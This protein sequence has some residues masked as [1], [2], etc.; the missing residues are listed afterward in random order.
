MDGLSA[1]PSSPISSSTSSATSSGRTL[2]C[3]GH[4]LGTWAGVHIRGPGRNSRAL[5][6]FLEP[7]VSHVPRR[8]TSARASRRLH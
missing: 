6:C 3:D 1:P 7:T 8:T 4:A 2:S 5:I